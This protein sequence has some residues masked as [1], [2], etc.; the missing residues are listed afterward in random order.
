MSM[1]TSSLRTV[2]LVMGLA[3]GGLGLCR[4]DEPTAEVGLNAQRENQLLALQ[5]Q[6]LGLAQLPAAQSY[7]D[8]LVQRIQ[9][10]GPQPAHFMQVRVRPRLSYN[11][12]STSEGWMV[13][14]LGW[15]KSIDSEPELA[16]L[17]SHEYAHLML[18]HMGTKNAL[19]TVTHMALAGAAIATGNARNDHGITRSLT[20]SGWSELVMPQ[21]SRSQELDADAFAVDITQSLGYAFVPSVRA[22]LER[23]QSVE[24]HGKATPA[25]PSGSGTDDH[26]SIEERIAQAQKLVEGRPRQR[27]AARGVDAWRAVRDSA[28]FRSQEAEYLVVAQCLQ[29]AATGDKNGLAGSMRALAALPQPLHTAAAQTLQAMTMPSQEPERVAAALT[30]ITEAPDASFAAYQLLARLQRDALGHYDTAVATLQAGLERF[31]SPPA[32]YP[33]VI[34]FQREVNERIDAL[35]QDQRSLGLSLYSVR[36]AASMLVLK[37]RCLADPLYAEPCSWASLNEAQRQAQIRKQ[38]ER[39]TAMEQKLQ[40]KVN[41]LFK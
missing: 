10:A 31:G 8:A 35:P 33:D 36:N 23:I 5:S 16:A 13:I 19:G 30:R 4:A 29:A 11:A 40:Q 7:L 15:L 32:L 12:F 18:G 37:T 21:W 26:P 22:F 25:V 38:Q 9:A 24:R 27:P 20:E 2:A 39:Q 3:A 41:K 14:D 34:T 28:D 17:L 6:E 1:F